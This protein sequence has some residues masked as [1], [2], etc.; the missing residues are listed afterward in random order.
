MDLLQVSLLA[1][2]GEGIK[3]RE[4]CNTWLPGWLAGQDSVQSA[5]FYKNQFP[6]IERIMMEARLINIDEH[7]KYYKSLS[8]F[9]F[10]CF[11]RETDS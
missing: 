3:A 2:T 6:I 5:A 4:T 7:A 1:K 9:S 11:F 8:V 10:S